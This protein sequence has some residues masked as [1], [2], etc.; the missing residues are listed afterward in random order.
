[1]AGPSSTRHCGAV[2]A[3]R[4]SQEAALS[5]ERKTLDIPV[6]WKAYVECMK[7]NGRPAVETTCNKAQR[8]WRPSSRL[9]TRAPGRGRLLAEVLPS[10]TCPSPGA[11]ER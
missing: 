1:M 10:V 7:S 6:D 4:D 5:S 2:Q 3:I 9:E 8:C 11:A